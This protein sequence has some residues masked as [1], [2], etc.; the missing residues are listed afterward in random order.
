MGA[1]LVFGI[2]YSSGSF[3]LRASVETT[4]VVVSTASTTTT[5]TTVTGG[6]GAQILQIQV[7]VVSCRIQLGNNTCLLVLLN[8]GTS[9]VAVEACKFSGTGGGAGVLGGSGPIGTPV[10]A[11]GTLSNVLCQAP[12]TLTPTA[13]QIA[14]G[15]VTLSNGGSALFSDTWE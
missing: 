5:T 1:G 3:N 6:G 8:S 13:G 14:S 12:V 10:P 15:S 2:I 9:S 11:G 4:T 7:S